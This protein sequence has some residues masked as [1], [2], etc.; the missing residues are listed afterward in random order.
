MMESTP[1]ITA[2]RLELIR[3]VLEPLR[4]EHADELAPALEDASLHRFIGGE[5]LGVDELR[6]RF[7]RQASGWSPDRR[8]RWLNWLVRQRA[9]DRAIGTVQATVSRGEPVAVAELAW[10]IGSPFQRQGFAKE[11]VGRVAA[12][13]REEGV[14]CLRAHIHPGH[15]ASM[16][17]ARSIGLRPT[18]VMVAGEIR[19]DSPGG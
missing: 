7:D 11:A 3:L 16:A 17:V 9:T 18:E 5:P 8:E 19:W 4:I 13:L 10:V 6:A 15:D 14:G 2:C 12:W 1:S